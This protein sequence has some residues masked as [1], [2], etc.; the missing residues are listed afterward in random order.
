MACSLTP[1]YHTAYSSPER[2]NMYASL[3]S[4]LRGPPRT[5]FTTYRSLIY[6]GGIMLYKF[7]LEFFTGSI[8]ALASDRF[9]ASAF[10]KRE[11][12]PP[13]LLASSDERETCCSRRRS[14]HQPGCAVRG[15]HPHRAHDQA[16]VHESR[17]RW[18]RIALWLDDRHPAHRGRC[19]RYVS[20]PLANIVPG[21][22]ELL[23]HNKG[24]KIKPAIARDAVY[25]SWNPDAVSP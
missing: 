7:G 25:G 14:G 24:G 16:L 5:K 1:R 18:F 2:R 8:T 12:V 6:V 22:L 23:P 3:Q 13:S 11:A 20:C 15:R 17:P 10:T 21:P 4:P 19:N 9:G